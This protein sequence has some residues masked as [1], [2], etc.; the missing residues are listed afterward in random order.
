MSDY[1]DPCLGCHRVYTRAVIRC[2]GKVVQ[3]MSLLAV[4]ADVA[5]SDGWNE[6]LSPASGHGATAVVQEQ[7]PSS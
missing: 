4:W 3:Q 1:S 6:R 2:Q 5:S 7:G